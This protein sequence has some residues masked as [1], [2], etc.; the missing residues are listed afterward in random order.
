MGIAIVPP[1]SG[2]IQGEATA[3]CE[4]DW[5]SKL[6]EMPEFRKMTRGGISDYYYIFR[7]AYM[8]GAAWAIEQYPR[9]VSE[10]LG[11]ST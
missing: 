10:E 5:L 7:I 6:K 2:T 9:W 4:A 11:A 1:E 8:A 3:A